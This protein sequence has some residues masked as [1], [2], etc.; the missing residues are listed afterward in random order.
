MMEN[1]KIKNNGCLDVAIVGGGP[2]GISAGLELS[3]QKRLKVALFER[4]DMLGGIPRSCHFFFGM[5]DQ[6]RLY[7]G[8]VYAHKLEQMINKTSVQ[9]KTGA[10]VL[11]IFPGSHGEPHQLEVLSPEGLMSYKSRFILLATGCCEG[12]RHK[13]MIPG[14]RPSGIF[15]T[16]TLQQL[17]NLDGMRFR[18]RRAVIVGSEHVAFSSVLTLRHAGASITAMVEESADIH[19]YE[20]LAEATK[21]FY[22]FP[23]YKDTSVEE[24]LGN[25]RVEGVALISNR[26]GRRFQLPCDM[27]VLTGRFQPESSL[28]DNTRIN[29]DPATSGPVVNLDMLTSVP[30][31]FA[32][33]NIL[34]GADM[35]DMCALEGRLAAR[36]IVKR[37]TSQD[38]GEKHWTPIKAEL[39]IRYVVPQKVYP[40]RIRRGC[41][42]RFFSGPAFQVDTTLKHAVLEAVSGE[43]RVWKGKFRKLIANNR[44]PLPVEKF[45]WFDVS[46]K[47]GIVLRVAST[48]A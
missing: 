22:G 48:S 23:I 40:D 45:D 42:G 28:I 4:D 29:R 30:N 9:I 27:V 31:I 35:H 15:T 43:N 44:Y 17:I 21:R 26:S 46:L 18:G 16:G 19:S 39:P 11:N 20:I 8:P 37:L 34:R 24:I 3:N 2:A 7:T 32:A 36:N 47:E 14:P 38:S 6:K 25:E 10:M 13:R 33:G 1:R 41:L 12:S 5:R